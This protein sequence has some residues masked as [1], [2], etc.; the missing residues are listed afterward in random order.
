MTEE[1]QE[2][3]NPEATVSELPEGEVQ[4]QDGQEP[5]MV[6]L[7]AM[8]ATRRKLQDAQAKAQ[9]ADAKAEL[10]YQELLK[11]KESKAQE[12]DDPTALVEKQTLKDVTQQTK[13]EIMETLFKDMNPE[14]VHEI[15]IYLDSILKKKPWL[16]NSV[17]SALNRYA[18]AYEIVQDYKHLV[19][20]KPSY[21]STGPKDAKKIVENAA[22]PRS[23]VEVGKSAQ[24]GGMDYLK[25]IQGKKEFREYRQKMLSGG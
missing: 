17:D 13:R 4:P 25:S 16:A 15:D 21:K 23:P 6:P 24:P 1:Y 11:E 12:P 7:A 10:L 8:I 14:A 19:E 9:Q 18:R 22:K 3:Q 5:K 20:E 2:E